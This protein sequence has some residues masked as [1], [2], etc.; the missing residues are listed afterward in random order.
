MYYR[1]LNITEEAYQSLIDSKMLSENTF[2]KAHSRIEN[3]TRRQ[4]VKAC[5][6][7]TTTYQYEVLFTLGWL[8]RNGHGAASYAQEY[9]TEDA[10]YP[11]R[12]L[13]ADT[14]YQEDLDDLKKTQEEDSSDG[15]GMG[16][17]RMLTQ[18]NAAKVLILRDALSELAELKEQLTK[19]V[20]R[21]QDLES[22]ILNE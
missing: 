21:I 12:K 4:L 10:K 8:R 15:A 19:T 22:R 2:S 14:K 7:S 5:Y 1:A 17:N 6:I 20:I 16:Q 11:L 9:K 18:K 3:G 13:C